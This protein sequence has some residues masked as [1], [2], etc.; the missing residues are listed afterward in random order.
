M[1]EDTHNATQPPDFGARIAALGPE[2]RALLARRLAASRGI[3]PQRPLTPASRRSDVAATSFAQQRL[4]L[5]DRLLPGGSE[6]NESFAA[7]LTGELHVEALRGA[8][9][10][11]VRRHDVLRARFALVDQSPVQVI[12]PQL[13][14]ALEVED[15][16]TVP[17][18]AR[19]GQALR[20]A[21]DEALA[22]FDLERGPLLRARLLRLG[23]QSHWLLVT[24]H[25]IVTDGWSSAV[26]A[27]E[28]SALYGAH[29]RGEVSPLAEL[30]VQYAD[31]AAWQREY[32]QGTVLDAQIGYWKRVLADLPEL[33]LPADRPRPAV[34]S[35]RGGSTR[36]VFGADLGR[37]LQDLGRR[38]GATLFMT[39]LAAFQVLLYRYTGQEDLAVGVPIAGRTRPEFEGLIG[40]FVN[41]LVLRGDLS[42]EPGFLEYLAQVRERALDAY[43]HQELPFEKLVEELAP[44]RVLS[45]NPLVQVSFNLVNVPRAGLELDGLIVERLPQKQTSVKFDL[46]LRVEEVAGRLYAAFEYSTDLFD[47]PTIERLAGHWRTLLQGIVA[48]PNMAITRLPLLTPAQRHQAVTAWNATAQDYPRDACVHTLFEAQ[49]ARTPDAVAVEFMARQLTYRELNAR[50]NRLAHH[51]RGLGVGPDVRVAVAMEKSFEL[52]VALLGILKAG[53]A[54]VPLEPDFPPQRLAF[55]LEDTQAIVLLTQRHLLGSMPPLRCRALC[56]DADWSSIGT[57]P[58]TNPACTASATNLAYVAYTSGSTGQPK[59]V[60][61]EHRGVCNHLH[62]FAHAHAVS[63]DD[64]V[65]QTASIGFDMS[66]WQLLLPLSCGARIVLPEPGAHRSGEELVALIRASGV[67]ILRLVPAMLSVVVDAPG[68]AQCASLRMVISAGEVLDPEL[69]RRLQALSNAELC[70]AY[71]PTETTF[72]TTLWTCRR[73]ETRWRIPVGRPI[74]NARVH[75]LDRLGEPVPIG[76]PGEVHIGGDGV[77]RGY[78][79][80]PD[81]D[82]ISF[83]ADPL[84]SAPDAR[85]YRTGDIARRLPDGNIDLLGR[86]DRQVKL[87]GIRVEPGEI[88]AVLARQ[89]QVRQAVVVLR[90]DVPGNKRL[91]A[92][93]CARGDAPAEVDLRAF[94]RQS[95]PDY[96]VPAAFVMLPELPLTRNGKVDRNALPAPSFDGDAPGHLPP[97]TPIEHGLAQ[98]MAEVLNL[99]RIGIDDNFFDLGG[100]SLSAVRLTS[101]I[102]DLLHIDLSLR[103]LFATPTVRGL[104]H[105]AADDPAAG[106]A[107]LPISPRA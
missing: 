36:F 107:V 31:Y 14:V 70:N 3:A 38:E 37:A 83:V 5:L 43:A 4:W 77:A 10:S 33:D 27:R 20:R 82:A 39:L 55:M 8:L 76:T 15:L 104:A 105:A 67:T 86:R 92:Y 54:Y 22:P 75:L 16:R 49:A 56:L 46:S 78:L 74:G 34:A 60:M 50:A 58:E 84:A 18:D 99:E 87:R 40:F 90:E 61:I 59:G 64:R 48:D 81:L 13:D 85:M 102:R 30:P 72:F 89:P 45:R 44:R 11:I 25:H 103:Q 9:N 68:F 91:V 62:G 106:V 2:Q 32:L 24:L 88:E 79:N 21:A 65:L 80:R 69:V 63:S 66:L 1:D 23:E 73:D 47:A 94:A 28:L 17:E 100:H 42:G 57:P 93:L 96:M 98:A 19:R 41:T 71:G 7:E 35:H 53:G 12:S 26:L 101:R 6:Y 52:V 97:R 29:C 95:L 51:L